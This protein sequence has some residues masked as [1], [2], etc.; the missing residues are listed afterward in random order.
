[1]SDDILLVPSGNGL[2]H[3]R[4]LVAI[5]NQL[6][7]KDISCGILLSERQNKLC[8]NEMTNSKVGKVI[9]SNSKFGLDGPFTDSI[10]PTLSNSLLNRISAA[11]IVLSDN[12]LWPS[13]YNDKVFLHGHFS[14]IDYWGQSHLIPPPEFQVEL[15]S[16]QW[17]N[18]RGWFKNSFFSFPQTI[19]K[20]KHFPMPLIRYRSDEKF[21]GYERRWG[22]VWV[23][24]GTTGDPVF[25]KSDVSE[26]NSR[27]MVLKC[28][29]TFQFHNKQSLPG[30]VI[31]RPGAGTLR[32]CLSSNTL[33]ISSIEDSLDPELSNNLAIMKK[34]GL[35]SPDLNI[36]IDEVKRLSSKYE[37]VWPQISAPIE[38]YVD[39]MINEISEVAS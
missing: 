21:S 1:M 24:V 29:E 10:T 15:E 19:I 37:Q 39:M 27:N 32:D 3:A 16:A 14:W 34:Q 22:E 31:G 35:T 7:R 2:G 12:V 30:V 36:S 38:E 4:R 5:Y 13:H 6:Q 33:F 25:S 8:S 18:I 17:K 9:I 23:S 28:L 20:A 11:S 26:I